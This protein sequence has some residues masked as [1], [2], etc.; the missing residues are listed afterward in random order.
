MKGMTCQ[1]FCFI[2]VLEDVIK[3]I[4]NTFSN[5]IFLN[6]LFKIV[7]QKI[8]VLVVLMDFQDKIA[9][10][11]INISYYQKNNIVIRNFLLQRN[12]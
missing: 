2:K 1:K 8:H 5:I 3:K 10:V 4:I 12:K 11:F 6:F 7:I 9:K